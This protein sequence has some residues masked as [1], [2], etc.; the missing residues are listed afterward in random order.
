MSVKSFGTQLQVGDAA[1]P[2]VFTAISEIRDLAITGRA[3]RM[4]ETTTTS[5]PAVSNSMSPE[6][7][8]VERSAVRSTGIPLRRPISP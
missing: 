6:R 8:T 2:E 4:F 3:R 1:T 7:W 5:R